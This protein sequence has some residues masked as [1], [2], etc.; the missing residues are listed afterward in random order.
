S[1]SALVPRR[2]A[3][4]QPANVREPAGGHHETDPHENQPEL[5]ILSADLR[6][7]LRSHGFGRSRRIQRRPPHR[8]VLPT[9]PDP[10]IPRAQLTSFAGTAIVFPRS[11][12]KRL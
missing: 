5:S 12:G 3:R 6:V 4:H 11:R 7:A 2:E 9:F 10:R 1:T 8:F